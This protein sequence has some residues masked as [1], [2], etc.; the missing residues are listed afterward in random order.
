MVRR[1][2]SMSADQIGEFLAAG[3]KLQVATLGSD[4][5]PHLT[6]LW[7]VMRAGLI[8]FRSF[9]KSQRIANLR[10]NPRLTVLVEAGDAYAELRGVMIKGHARLI[11][12]RPTVLEVYGQIATKHE[13]SGEAS[14]LDPDALEMLF[15][16]HADKNTVVMVE[17]ESVAS[18]DH[19]KLG[20]AY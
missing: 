7:Y 19:R 2:I 9:S 16:R 18:W 5:H 10:R 17:P 20:G 6:T 8:T 14:P 3:R 1:D 12:D 4:G 13:G 11:E 15:G